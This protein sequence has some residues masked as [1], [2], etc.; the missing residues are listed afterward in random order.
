M[1]TELNWIDA[2]KEKPNDRRYVIVWEGDAGPHVAFWNGKTWDD[3]DFHDDID[4]ITHWADIIG[5]NGE[6][7][8]L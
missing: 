5:P 3:G 8:D 6:T 4:G 7:M 2:S 1:K